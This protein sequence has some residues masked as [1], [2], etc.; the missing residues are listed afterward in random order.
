MLIFLG[1]ASCVW[2][3]CFLLVPETKKRSFS[4]L[5]ELFARRIPAWRFAKT[6]TAE[7]RLGKEMQLG[8]AG[9]M[10]VLTAA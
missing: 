8:S 3:L 5:D 4:E 6:E 2:I 7:Q 10:P 9:A 1:T